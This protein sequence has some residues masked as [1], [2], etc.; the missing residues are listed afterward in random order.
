MSDTKK[1]VE[2]LFKAKILSGLFKKEFLTKAITNFLPLIEKKIMELLAIAEFLLRDGQTH[3]SLGEV[4]AAI[5]CAVFESADIYHRQEVIGM[6]IIHVGSG[7]PWE[8]NHALDALDGIAQKDPSGV[9]R[10][11]IFVKGI[12]D[13]LDR[14]T[15]D[16]VSRLFV[17]YTTL[18]IEEDAG[19]GGLKNDLH[20]IIRKQLTHPA[21]KYKRIG[22]ISSLAMIKQL[23]AHYA[24]TIN[25]PRYSCGSST[26]HLHP[27]LEQAISMLQL[28]QAACHKS[29]ASLPVAY[30][31]LSQMILKGELHADVIQWLFDN[32]V[33]LF[34]D[35]FV[36]ESEDGSTAP[37][38][39]PSWPESFQLDV[40]DDLNEG[41]ASVAINI[42]P[43]VVRHFFN[44]RKS[45]HPSF[46]CAIFNL[47]QACEKFVNGSLEELDALLGCGIV[48][49][50]KDLLRSIS[51]E[52]RDDMHD[53]LIL[54]M[55]VALNWYR[56]LINA[57]HTNADPSLSLKVKAR[58]SHVV[59]I[60]EILD[61]FNVYK[62]HLSDLEASDASRKKPS[63][64][65][66]LPALKSALRLGN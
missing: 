64:Q 42:L 60:E 17:I 44:N 31:G 32:V 30:N 63:R 29:V 8:I 39:P 66:A 58:I 4:S 6:L 16:Q 57:F 38:H 10:F 59:Q 7:N 22:I 40:W 49:F 2:Q 14:L 9:L 1:K 12:L 62:Y 26:N 52:D 27:I 15:L 35:L 46:I 28:L 13:Y 18:A 41:S 3:G 11:A 20:M 33:V 34:A 37:V 19:E 47:Y 45:Y 48:M 54:S 53:C 5:Y 51:K 56:E 50:N 25:D 43:T 61:D 21:E 65:Q 55:V 23:S 24:A 36:I